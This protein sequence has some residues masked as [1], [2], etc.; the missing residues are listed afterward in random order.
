MS[1]P[2]SFSNEIK[3]TLAYLLINPKRQALLPLEMPRPLLEEIRNH[4][5]ECVV[6]GECDLEDFFDYDGQL[7]HEAKISDLYTAY[8]WAGVNNFDII[9]Q[10]LFAFISDYFE[11]SGFP[12]DELT[13]RLIQINDLANRGFRIINSREDE[14]LRYA[15]HNHLCHNV[16]GLWTLSP[17]GRTLL[18]L[19]ELQI[20]RFL[21]GIETYTFFE[22]ND[23]WRI[24]PEVLQN[25]LSH[26]K[27]EFSGDQSID[28]SQIEYKPAQR[29]IEMGLAEEEI[30]LTLY[31][32]PL[33]KQVIESVLAKDSYF[34][35]LLPFFFREEII[36]SEAPN[37]A[38][39]EDRKRF[40]QLINSSPIAGDLKNPILEEVDL[41][42]Q[43]DASYLSIFKALAP[44]IEG[45]LRNI[46]A[47]ESVVSKETGVNA[48][49]KALR[50]SGRAILKTST[51]EL[52][53]A[54]F[55]PYRNV[56]EHGYFMPPEPARML[57]E[58]TLSIIE[59]IHRDYK[60]Y[61]GLP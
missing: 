9:R 59:Q 34:D 1:I 37:F 60:D 10:L 36:G 16:E 50:Q 33:G 12:H 28:S 19:P 45:L 40:H 53:D 61:K 38:T 41:L 31:L 7:L 8:V 35:A 20:T 54:L 22:Y 11:V 14:L 49:L 39:T 2:I 27:Y 52:I 44:N 47:V 3:N 58:L 57:C 30:D 32:Y 56:A 23:P 55:K 17:L 15:Q 43:V 42:Y 51:L 26:G 25:L 6:V 29:L 4:A 24:S 46:C 48:Y 18:R 5:K 21:L 13:Y